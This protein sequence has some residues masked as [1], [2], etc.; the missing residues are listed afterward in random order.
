M[1][2][3]LNVAMPPAALTVVV[4]PSVPPGPALLPIATV[5]DAVEDDTRLSL[6]SRTRTVTAGVID[7]PAAEFVG[8]CPN[9]RCVDVDVQVSEKLTPETFA[10]LLGITTS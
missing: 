1:E 7:A 2:R 10:L 9:A 8:C 4:P 3:L 6:A 5:I